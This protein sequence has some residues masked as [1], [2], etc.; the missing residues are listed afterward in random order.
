V[1][2]LVVLAISIPLAY[3]MSVLIEEPAIR[4]GRRL[5]QRPSAPAMTGKAA[6]SPSAL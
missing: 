1:V 5:T 3:L 6:I 4:L 2:A